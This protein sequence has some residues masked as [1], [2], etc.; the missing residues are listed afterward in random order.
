MPLNHHELFL[1][2]QKLEAAP[3]YL[4]SPAIRT[5]AAAARIETEDFSHC[6]ISSF[7]LSYVLDLLVMVRTHRPAKSYNVS[8]ISDILSPY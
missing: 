8:I 7:D 2:Y 6:P 1:G 4:R 3:H 5:L